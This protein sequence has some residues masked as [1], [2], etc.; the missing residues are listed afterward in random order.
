MSTIGVRRIFKANVTNP[1]APDRADSYN[2]G[3]LVVSGGKIEQLSRED[4]RAAF[5]TAEFINCGWKTIMPGF[6]DIHVHLPH[7]ATLG[8]AKALG[9][10]DRIGN[11]EPGKDADFVVID[12]ERVEEVYIRGER[13]AG[14]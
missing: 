1:I 8:G 13:V 6:I 14:V 2:P 10:A 7:L 9:L 3:Y 4:P 12:Q 5:R 11:F